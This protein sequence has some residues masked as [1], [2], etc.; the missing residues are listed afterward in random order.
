MTGPLVLPL[1][2][3]GALGFAGGLAPDALRIVNARHEGPPAFLRSAFFWGSLLVLGALGGGVAALSH[4]S[5]PEAALALGYFAPSIVS[6]L[7]AKAE[8]G[9]GLAPRA[10]PRSSLARLRAWWAR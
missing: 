3:A 9:G 4:P 1:W 5:S 7:G 8:P 6:A 2:E 10:R